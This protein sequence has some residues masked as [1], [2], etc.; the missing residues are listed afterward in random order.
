MEKR[1]CN[2]NVKR[3]L[4]ELVNLS[5]ERNLNFLSPFFPFSVSPFQVLITPSSKLHAPCLVHNFIIKQE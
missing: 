4:G 2:E 5:K 3:S 1:N